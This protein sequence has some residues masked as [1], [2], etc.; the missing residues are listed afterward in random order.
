M[1]SEML[2]Q[3]Q[4]ARRL[5]RD[6]ARIRELVARGV[7]QPAGE[8]R[9]ARFEW[10]TALAA[11]TEYS[12]ERRAEELAAELVARAPVG[13]EDA[14]LRKAQADAMRAEL[15]V[16][17]E[18]GDLILQSDAEREGRRF[19]ERVRALLLAVPS[20]YQ[21]A[22]AVQLGVPIPVAGAAL[23]TMSGQLL[24]DLQREAGTAPTEEEAA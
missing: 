20:R 16:K 23:R 18:M 17:R 8:G 3:T 4:L 9:Q 6:P 11:W 12:A 1:T 24:G 2:T 21:A 22:F 10:R 7:L 5:G 19:A 13:L 15:R 14:Q